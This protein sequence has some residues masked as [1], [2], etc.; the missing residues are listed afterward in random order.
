VTEINHNGSHFAGEK[1]D[2]VDELCGVLAVEPLDRAFEAF[3]NFILELTDDGGL[4]RF[5]GNFAK[6]SHVFSIDT[7]EP[8]VIEQLT[9][10]IRENQQRPDYLS[11]TDRK[12]GSK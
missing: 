5:W 8:T 9:T 11:Q 7:D 6:V 3:G 1:P 12:G 2:T 4:L 10:A